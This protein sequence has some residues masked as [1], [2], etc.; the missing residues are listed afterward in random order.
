[1]CRSARSLNSLHS[2]HPTAAESQFSCCFSRKSAGSIA[3]DRCSS[4]ALLRQPGG[5]EGLVPRLEQAEAHH[6]GVLQVPEAEELALDPDSAA[7]AR[8]GL[9]EDQHDRVPGVHVL[10]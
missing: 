7:P 5:F 8:P 6:L 3:L 2:I 9:A 10:A 1:M 4:M